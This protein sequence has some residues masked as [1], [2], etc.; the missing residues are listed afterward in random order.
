[1]LFS[2]NQQGAIYE[3]HRLKLSIDLPLFPKSDGR[4]DQKALHALKNSEPGQI[5]LEAQI[6]HPHWYY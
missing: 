2:R 6:N 4:A 3:T 1:M 5:A